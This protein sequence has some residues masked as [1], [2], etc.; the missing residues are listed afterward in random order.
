MK[1]M[2]RFMCAVFGHKYFLLQRLSA[3]ARKVGCR[4]CGKQWGMHDPTESLVI[5]DDDLEEL[6][7]L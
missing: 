2:N 5:W 4:R 7:K 1:I 6:Y 3:T